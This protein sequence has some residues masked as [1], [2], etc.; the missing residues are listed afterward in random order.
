MLNLVI[1][2]NEID[3]GDL[4]TLGKLTHASA[5]E[6]ITATAF[7]LR[8][9]QPAAQVA[10][11]VA[12]LCAR[13]RLD[14]AYV[15]AGRR[16]TDY[17]LVVMDMDSTLI[18]IE[19]IDEIADIQGIKRE[20]AA[21]TAAAMRGEIDY[22]ESLKRR[23]QLLSGLEVTALDQVYRERL[24]LSAGAQTMIAAMRE[25]GL[26]TLLVSG[27]FSY[28]TER[29]KERLGLDAAYSNEPRIVA[30]RLTGEV[31]GDVVD[32]AAKAR[33][34]QRMREQL[35][36]RPDQVIGIGD[37]ANDLPFLTQAGV[38]IAFHAKPAVRSA[39]THCLDHV[40]L[41]GVLA[42]FE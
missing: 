7:R 24:Q 37:G 15:P 40:G 5:I 42:L 27:G 13:A 4:K 28:F 35:G 41:D 2:G 26:R 32:G 38:S 10:A 14:H 29:L 17:G 34:A 33:A 22:T 3:T 6:R 11:E 12:T 25:A 16:L 8:A 18:T 36:L 19:C 1:Q 31:L 30:G 20:V 39:T 21:I 23:V 9:V